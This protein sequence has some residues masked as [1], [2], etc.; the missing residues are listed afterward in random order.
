MKVDGSRES[1]IPGTF[2]E[3]DADGIWSEKVS[4]GEQP[5]GQAFQSPGGLNV[6]H[7]VDGG[8]GRHARYGRASYVLGPSQVPSEHLA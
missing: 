3:Y 7:D 6:C 1:H 5:R 2:S 4:D 8:F